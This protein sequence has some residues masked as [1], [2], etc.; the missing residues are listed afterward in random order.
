MNAVQNRPG[1]PECATVFAQDLVINT[2]GAPHRPKGSDDRGTK[3][4]AEES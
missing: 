3:G 1:L 4:R 2:A